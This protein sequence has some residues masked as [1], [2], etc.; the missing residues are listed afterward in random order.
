MVEQGWT[1]WEK[2][3]SGVSGIVHVA[4]QGEV[5]SRVRFFFRLVIYPRAMT[6]TL[7]CIN[8]RWTNRDDFDLHPHMNCWRETA[9]KEGRGDFPLVRW[10]PG[11][12]DTRP[13]T[14]VVKSS[15]FSNV[16]LLIFLTER[17]SSFSRAYISL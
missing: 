8:N 4:I 7:N 9:Q 1:A 15:Q 3:G 11:G 12:L 5:G 2:C 13:E 14:G 17:V 16:E 6:I 10:G